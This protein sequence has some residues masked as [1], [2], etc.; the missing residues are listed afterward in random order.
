MTRQGWAEKNSMHHTSIINIQAKKNT[1]ESFFRA[2]CFS[3]GTGKQMAR[4]VVKQT[5]SIHTVF[6]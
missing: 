4:D 1:H 6:K 2:M 3:A 5:T